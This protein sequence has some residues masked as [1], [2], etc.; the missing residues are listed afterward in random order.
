MTDL[1]HA[2]HVTR[3]RRWAVSSLILLAV[4]LGVM[5]AAASAGNPPPV[6]AGPAS[7]FVPSRNANHQKPQ[8]GHGVSQLLY[9][10][11]P[12]QSLATLAQPTYLCGAWSRTS[13]DKKV[14]GPRA[15]YPPNGRKPDGRTRL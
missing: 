6:A 9:N 15:H 12:V 2:N 1:T 7:G 11:G 4:G 13:T 14:A 5:V 10:V 8:N 3:S